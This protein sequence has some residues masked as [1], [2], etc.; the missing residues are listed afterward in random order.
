MNNEVVIAGGS[1]MKAV[2]RTLA[3]QSGHTRGTGRRTNLMPLLR[4]GG[5]AHT[6]SSDGRGASGFEMILVVGASGYLGGYTIRRLLAV[7][8]RVRAASRDRQKLVELQSSGAE[9]VQADLVDRR[10]LDAACDGVD[11]VLAASHSL[12]GTG[13]YS[14]AA[15]DEAGH[16]ALIDAAASAGVRRF[17]YTSAMFASPDHPVDF[18]RNKAKVEAHLAASG[19]SYAILRPSAFMEWHVHNLLGK[20]LVDSGKATIF[21]PGANPI[22]FVAADDVAA[23]AAEMLT[24]AA[25]VAAT[26]E[27]GGPDNFTRNAVAAMY[28]DALNRP[29]ALRHVSLAAMRIAAP[30]VRPFNPVLAR[31]MDVSVWSETSNQVFD[32]ASRTER[33]ARPMTHVRDFI[34]SRVADHLDATRLRRAD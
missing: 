30:L 11:A 1:V 24:I 27:V 12:L 17:V 28:G 4:S 19:L 26:L 33:C 6:R 5:R 25:D 3:P 21:G 22:N 15:V 14:S 16:L 10:S 31:L 34:A 29:I 8:R 2:T 18:L 9:L 23:V 20:S 7:G 32:F 13:K